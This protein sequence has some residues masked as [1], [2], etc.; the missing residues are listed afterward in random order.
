MKSALLASAA[1]SLTLSASAYAEQL[2]VPSRYDKRIGEFTYRPNDVYKIWSAPA[3]VMTLKFADDENFDAGT[4]ADACP[5]KYKP[6]DNCGLSLQ[7]RG[8]IVF[9][10][11]RKCLI[12]QMLLI[13]MK[14]ADGK[15]RTYAFETHTEPQICGGDEPVK[16]ESGVKL[17]SSANAATA[18]SDIGAGD[19]KY[20]STNALTQHA[21]EPVHYSIQFRYPGDEAAKSHESAK[22]RRKREEK[23]AIDSALSREV[24]FATRDPFTGNRHIRYFARGSSTIMPRN[25]WDNGYLTACTFPD[26]QRMPS[27]YRLANPNLGC[28][29]D[30][31]EGTANYSVR[32]DT[33]ILTGTEHSWCLRDGDNVVQIW[34][35][36]YSPLGSTPGTGTASPNV[37]RI[38]R[39][40]STN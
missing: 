17:V 5:D 37:E 14:P 40:G 18:P 27:V 38:V 25:C 26:L 15:L 9:L 1:L 11:F 4:S 28:T 7:P 24:D 39:G 23:E 29:V 8:N 13:S 16:G 33:M 36:D 30:G 10:K 3:G 21:A 6:E 34:N 12:P 35:L 2:P 31:K 32:G 20:I 19:L 22:A